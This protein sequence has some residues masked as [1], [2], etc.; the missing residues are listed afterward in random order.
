MSATSA[1]FAKFDDVGPRRS[2]IRHGAFHWGINAKH[3]AVSRYF[4][5]FVLRK[6]ETLLRVKYRTT[7]VLIQKE[8]M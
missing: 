3:I 6:P 1:V 4:D 2:N 8:I 7:D 5:L